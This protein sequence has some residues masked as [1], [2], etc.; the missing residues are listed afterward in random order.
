MF[1]NINTLIIRLHTLENMY[2]ECSNNTFMSQVTVHTFL[3]GRYISFIQYVARKEVHL[4][5]DGI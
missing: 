2:N 3:G 1:D 5:V 4:C